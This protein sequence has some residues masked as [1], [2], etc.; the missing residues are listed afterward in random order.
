MITSGHQ[1]I[2]IQRGFRNELE[3][4]A[5]DRCA[6]LMPKPCSNDHLAM[7][8]DLVDL[9]QGKIP[10][11]RLAIHGYRMMGK[12]RW[13][14]PIF[15]PWLI[16]ETDISEIQIISQ[17]GGATGLSSKIAKQIMAELDD[18]VKRFD[19]QIKQGK[20]WGTEH[21]QVI[22]ANGS[23]IDIY[24]RGKR[25]S[26]RGQ[27]GMIIFEDIQDVD[28]VKSETV[29]E[30]DE[31]WFFGDAINVPG[32]DDLVL[33]VSNFLSPVSLAAKIETLAGWTVRK[34]Y[35]ESEVGSFKSSWPEM[36]SESYLRFKFDELGRDRF[37][38]EYRLQPR[39][40]GNPVFLREWFRFYDPLSAEYREIE[41]TQR[42]IILGY[43][44]A[45]SVS[46]SAD[47]T[48]I[49]TLSA[50]A[51][52]NDPNIYVG[53]VWFGNVSMGDGLDRCFRLHS[54]LHLSEAIIES[55]VK[56]DN[57]GPQEEYITKKERIEGLTFPYSIVKPEKDKVTRA[58]YT[59]GTVQRGKI[60]LNPKDPNHQ[61]LL[62]QLILFTGDQLAKDDG[63]DAF[64]H[65]LTAM[66]DWSKRARPVAYEVQYDE[67]T[68]RPLTV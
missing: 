34:Y 38:A 7:A 43:D 48:A 16:C 11:N 29:L 68:G 15:L 64:V 45:D 42:H 2:A 58:L 25:S 62:T 4:W 20:P 14:G 47:E 46:T 44:G 51:Y 50:R 32:P 26:L 10:N 54:Q 8:Q 19:Y 52:M 49:V 56:E 65:G 22:R 57:M 23:T 36:F 9:V 37:N 13:I 3:M 5:E 60:Y 53:E 17:S 21:F 35:A 41:Q 27:R 39:V 59:Q 31:E 67:V 1:D 24:C 55:R 30:R 28:D 33:W 63:V 12:T 40:P 66:M 18:P 6:H 61:K